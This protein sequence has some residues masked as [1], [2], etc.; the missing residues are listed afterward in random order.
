MFEAQVIINIVVVILILHE[1]LWQHIPGSYL[2]NTSSVI[3]CDSKK[4][5]PPP[6]KHFQM[7]TVPFIP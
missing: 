6:Q 4:V 3:Y 5:Q 7:P 1:H 2:L